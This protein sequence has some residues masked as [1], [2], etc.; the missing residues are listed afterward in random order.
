MTTATH[1]TSAF[2]DK[3]ARKYA[4]QKIGDMASYEATLERTR[5]YLKSDDNVLEIGAGTSSTALVLAPLV[6]HYTSSDYSA[7]MVKIGREKLAAAPQPNLEI[8]QGAPGDAAIA[9][10]YDTVM[11]FNL[12]HLLPDLDQGIREAG[13]LIRPRGLLICKTPCLGHAWYMKAMIAVMKRVYGIK[14]V[15][16][17]T[18]DELEASVKA[19]GFEIIEADSYTKGRSRY[20]V[21]RKVGQS[22]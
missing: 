1:P 19:A 14:H 17:F 18:A 21:V 5:S 3:M 8:V 15:S 22:G 9:G 10:E 20:I 4:K 11:A 13:N 16:M 12:L 7:E 2:W 6:G